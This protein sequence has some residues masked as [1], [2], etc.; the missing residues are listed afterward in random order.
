MLWYCVQ[1][2][3][4]RQ[5]ESMLARLAEADKQLA[6]LGTEKQQLEQQLMRA[7]SEVQTRSQ[8]AADAQEK[9]AR[10]IS[11]LRQVRM[12]SAVAQV[13]ITKSFTDSLLLGSWRSKVA[14][15]CLDLAQQSALVCCLS[16]GHC[17]AQGSSKG[18]CSCS[19]SSTGR[20]EESC[21][22]IW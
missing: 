18:S 14:N 2:V 9:A 20:C 15:A 1:S 6:V 19:I 10:E 17:N 3:S 4:A 16:V 12:P 21:E 22:G 13:A 8:A 11:L 5:K 7:V